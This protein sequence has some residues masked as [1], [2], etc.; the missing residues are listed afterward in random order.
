MRQVFDHRFSIDAFRGGQLVA[1]IATAEHIYVAF[2][3]YDAACLHHDN[4][5][6]TIYLRQGTR[7]MR[8]SDR[9]E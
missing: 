7:I 8:R 4:P 5:A 1:Q 9:P 3:A 2:A 6:D